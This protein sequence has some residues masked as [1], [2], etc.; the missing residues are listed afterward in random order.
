MKLGT[1]IAYIPLHAAGDL[2]GVEDILKHPDVEFGFVTSEGQGGAIHFCRYWRKG[3]L[4]EL[5]TCAN[6]EATPTE[7]LMEY[8]SV[9]QEIVDR[10]VDAI[11]RDY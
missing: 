8:D 11:M 1:Q 7:M 5:R 9:P 10:L 2:E 3:Y 6:S 4:G